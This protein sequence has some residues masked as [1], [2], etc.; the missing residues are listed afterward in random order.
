LS[1]AEKDLAKT[2]AGAARVQALL[3]TE[4]ITSAIWNGYGTGKR[5]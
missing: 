2:S 3:L 1:P 4:G 5:T